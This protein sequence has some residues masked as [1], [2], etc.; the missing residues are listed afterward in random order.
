MT[1]PITDTDSSAGDGRELDSREGNQADGTKRSFVI[2]TREP[3]Q[4]A[5]SYYFKLLCGQRFQTGSFKT[6]TAP[7]L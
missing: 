2:G 1:A 4:P 6:A 7:A 5:T 3:L